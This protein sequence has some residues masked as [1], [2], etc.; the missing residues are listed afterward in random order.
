[1]ENISNTNEKENQASKFKSLKHLNKIILV[2][3]MIIMVVGTIGISSHYII[4]KNYKDNL[5]V[6]IQISTIGD[7]LTQGGHK[8][9]VMGYGKEYPNCYQNYLYEYLSERNIES[10]VRNFGI[11]GQITSQICNRFNETV[12]AEYIVS[13]S[14]TNDIWR[15]NYSNSSVNQT[16]ADLI[17]T[18]YN[19][20]ITGTIS[21]QTALNYSSP[22]VIICSVPPVGDVKTLPSEMNGAILYVNAKL[23]LFVESLNSSNIVFCDVN[24][25]MRNS[26]NYLIEGLGTADGVHFTQL[27]NLVCGEAISQCIFEQYYK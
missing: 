18:K 11:S 17:I 4:Q 19:Q 1:M 5:T 23:E 8:G 26:D 25:N 21:F 13:M 16:L 9:I 7:S 24:K 20:T 10:Q 14:G 2:F 12:P 15:A 3:F 27:G 6:D 22:K